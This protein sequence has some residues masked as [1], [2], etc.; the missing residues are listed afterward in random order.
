[1]FPRSPTP[2]RLLVAVLTTLLIAGAS[3]A[4]LAAQTVDSSTPEVDLEDLAGYTVSGDPFTPEDPWVDPVGRLGLDRTD[5]A[6]RPE[7]DRFELHE[8]SIFATGVDRVPV[9]LEV[10]DELAD[11]YQL[12]QQVLATLDRDVAEVAVAIDELRP[13]VDRLLSRISV[14]QTHEA[15]LERETQILEDAIAEFAVRAFIAED[16]I[17]TAFDITSTEFSETRIVTDDVREDQV[18]QIGVRREELAARRERRA[19]YEQDLA[20]TRDELGVLRQQRLELLGQRR[21]VAPLLQRIED[22]YQQELHRGL[23]RFVE[24]T[25]IPLVALNAYVIAERTLAEE[26][27]ECGITWSMLAGIGHVESFHGHFGDSTL[28][29]NGHTTEDIRGLPLDGR[30]LSG[31]ELLSEDSDTPSPTSRS[32][33]LEVPVSPTEPAPEATP[34]APAPT[35]PVTASVG[36]SAGVAPA[37]DADPRAPDAGDTAEA[38]PAPVVIR[39]LALILDSDDG[40]LDGDTTYDRAVGPMQ[41]IPSTWRLFEQDGNLDEELDPQNIYDASLASARYL[42]ASTATMTTLAGELRAYFA[43][44][45]DTE[46]SQNVHRNGQ[47]Y[48][49]LVDVYDPL[50]ANETN[51]SDTFDD[52]AGGHYLGIADPERL[53]VES[54]IAASLRGLEGIGSLDAVLG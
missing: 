17:G 9:G 7:F 45:H 34:E 37:E 36:P 2:R 46:Y 30:I 52:G 41:F 3:S 8:S 31:A 54:Q 49:T 18:A 24:G 10:L 19:G 1:M 38:A 33:D 23:P 21:S 25:N 15:R 14:E 40:I 22:T 11:R 28:D 47:R 39:R 6:P 26:R 51:A 5:L 13:N 44:N 35:E 12:I 27:P 29:I 32:E 50:A 4:P 48:A 53:S 43:Y 16:E 20:E 42:C